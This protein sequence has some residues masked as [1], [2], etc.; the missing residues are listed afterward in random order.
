MLALIQFPFGFFVFLR[1]CVCLC[2]AGVTQ[3]LSAVRQGALFA[4]L[5][6]FSFW[7]CHLLFIT[8]VF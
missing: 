4:G 1:A 6:F 7:F 8:V 5:Y 2:D 3:G